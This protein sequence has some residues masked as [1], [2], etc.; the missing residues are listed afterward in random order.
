[1]ALHRLHPVGERLL[2]PVVPLVRRSG[3]TSGM[4]SELAFLAAV[5]AAVTFHQT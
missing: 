3:F 2:A 1:M 5:G 4:V